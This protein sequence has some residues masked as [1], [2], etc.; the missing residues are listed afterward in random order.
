[1]TIFKRQNTVTSA[2]SKIVAGF[3]RSFYKAE[4][5]FGGLCQNKIV[6]GHGKYIFEYNLKANKWN[7]MEYEQRSPNDRFDAQGCIMN[8]SLLLCGDW[9]RSNVELLTFESFYATSLSCIIGDKRQPTQ[10]TIC[11]QTFCP[12]SLPLDVRY[13]T[14]TK[15]EE[16]KVMLVGGVFNNVVSN[17]VFQGTLTNEHKD[18]IWEEL[19][20]LNTARFRHVT[21]KM[22]TNVYVFGG[23]FIL[24]SNVTSCERYDLIERSW[25]NCLHTLP[26]RLSYAS[27]IVSDDETFAVIIGGKKDDHASNQILIFTEQDGFKLSNKFILKTE[28][29]HHIS[30]KLNLM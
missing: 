27:V 26:Y 2:S 11:I 22:K 6:V 21:F 14:I 3:P 19:E 7:R 15:I 10:K 17:R 8:K 30:I 9:N 25:K 18:V 23:L 24:H 20:S 28:R 16:N 13:H 5:A 4:G 29:F 12:T 1:M